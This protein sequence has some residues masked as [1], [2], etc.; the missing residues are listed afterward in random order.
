MFAIYKAY[1]GERKRKDIGD[2][3]QAPYYPSRADHSWKIR[4][5]VRK[6]SFVNRTIAY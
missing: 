1:N 6:F 4:T 2:R 3:L 5:D